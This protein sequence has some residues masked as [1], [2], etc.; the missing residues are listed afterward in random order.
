MRYIIFLLF[1]CMSVPV[2]ASDRLTEDQIREFFKQMSEVQLQDQQS[3]M[4]FY[5]THIHNDAKFTVN[6]TAFIKGSKPIVETKTHDKKSFINQKRDER[7]NT[8]IKSLNHTVLNVKIA[9]DGKSAKVKDSTYGIS[10][11]NVIMNEGVLVVHNDESGICEGEIILGDNGV[12]QLKT[13]KCD[14]EITKETIS[15]HQMKFESQTKQD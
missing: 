3:A 2:F 8:K 12:L 13:S 10:I 6:T 9:R 5:E 15:K 14:I 4:T 11:A 1:L 7:K